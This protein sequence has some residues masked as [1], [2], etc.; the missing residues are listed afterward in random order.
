MSNYTKLL[1]NLDTLKLF[2]IKD[3]IDTYIN[4]I[5]DKEKN[6]VDSLYE[7]TT[8]ELNF[9][10]EKAITS[11]V[12]MAG[13]PYQKTL[14]DFDFNFQPSINKDKILDLKNLRFLENK[15]KIL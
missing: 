1:N 2:K 4:L 8:L 9:K 14:D 7:L 15:E 6:I 13:F 12:R 10:K 3:N 5:N 11:L